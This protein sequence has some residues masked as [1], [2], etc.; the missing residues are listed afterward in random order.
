MREAIAAWAISAYSVLLPIAQ[1]GF[2]IGVFVLLPMA[3]FKRSRSSAGTGL[4]L[5]S[6]LI[7]LTTWLLGAA[8]TFASFGWFGLILGLLLAGIGVVPLA[9]IAA[10][11]KLEIVSMGVSLIVMAII[12]IAA[13]VGG[14]ALVASA[15]GS[16]LTSR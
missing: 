5:V 4:V 1:I 6:Y 2:I 14:L 3:L 10:F 12:T 15:D 8:I 11:F 16:R 7:G 13:R 9:V